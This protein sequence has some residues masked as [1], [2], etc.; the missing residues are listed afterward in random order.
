[1]FV[2]NVICMHTYL[3][4]ILIFTSIFVYAKS[5]VYTFTSVKNKRNKT[6]KVQIIEYYFLFQ[7]EFLDLQ[8][9]SILVDLEKNTS[10]I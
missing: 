5:L 3:Y 6:E 7:K 1:M 10:H 4:N 8:T 9:V 2:V